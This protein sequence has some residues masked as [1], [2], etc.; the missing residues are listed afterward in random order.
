MHAWVYAYLKETVV[1]KREV[2]PLVH[3]IVRKI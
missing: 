3:S 1:A 2:A